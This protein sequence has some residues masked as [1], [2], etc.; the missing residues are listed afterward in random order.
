[1]HKQRLFIL[2]ASGAGVLGLLLTWFSI[3]SGFF[4]YS[5]NGFSSG[6]TGWGTLLAIGAAAGL[7]FKTDDKNLVLDSQTKKM[8]AG[9]GLAVIVLPLLAILVVKMQTGGQ[10]INLGMGLFI[11]MLSGL[12]IAA[13]PFA[14]KEDGSFEMPNKETIKSDL[15]KDTNED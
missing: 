12:A 7:I 4:S 1:M 14:I 11:C 2:I 3:D 10:F 6:W 8:V 9:A 13:L 5:Q 15:E